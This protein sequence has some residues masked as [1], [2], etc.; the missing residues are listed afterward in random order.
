MQSSFRNW[1]RIINRRKYISNQQLFPVLILHLGLQIFWRI[2]LMIKAWNTWQEKYENNNFGLGE[3]YFC[4]PHNVVLFR[5][6]Y[7]V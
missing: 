1:M 5:E 7:F 6:T 2:P 3:N 4:E